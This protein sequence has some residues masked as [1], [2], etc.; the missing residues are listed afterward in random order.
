M[1]LSLDLTKAK[2]QLM[3]DL[4]KAGV[5]TPPSADAAFVLDVSGSFDDE[6][7]GGLTQ[8]LLERLVPWGMVFDPDQKIDVLTFSKGPSYAH[9][10]GDITPSTCEGYIKR[11]IINKVPG[12]GYGTDYSYVLQKCLELFGWM[13]SAQPQPAKKSWFFSKPAVAAASAPVA[14]RRSI[15][16][17]VTDGANGDERETER[18]LSESSARSD[19][20]YFM[21]LGISNQ[22]TEFKFLQRM[23]DR[24]DNT[25]LTIIKDLKVFNRLSD[26]EINNLLI[27]DELV[28]WL[29][30]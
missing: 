15:V 14:K 12:Y 1:A 19:G 20:V 27:T 3:L 16:M 25:G 21:F 2:A 11:S 29:K 17:F 9:H 18:L 22:P 6:H 28:K 7:Q 24:F 8:I 13:P 23:G 26:S 5:T 10:V 30:S 4:S